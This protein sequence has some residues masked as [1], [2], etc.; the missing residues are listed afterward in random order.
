MPGAASVVNH[1]VAVEYANKEKAAQEQK[2][3]Q[4]QELAKEQE[5]MPKEKENILSGQP[6][7]RPVEDHMPEG[8]PIPRLRLR[9]VAFS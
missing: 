2:V 1:R 7:G 3:A 6:A 4:E 8:R 9:D 5:T